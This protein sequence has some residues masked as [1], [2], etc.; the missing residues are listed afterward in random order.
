MVVICTLSPHLSFNCTFKTS[1]ALQRTSK[2][3]SIPRLSQSNKLCQLK[4]PSVFIHNLLRLKSTETTEFKTSLFYQ[5]VLEN[6]ANLPS[7]TSFNVGGFFSF[8][9]RNVSFL[10]INKVGERGVFYPLPCFNYTIY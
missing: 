4:K 5:S 1:S 2:L 7:I 8:L 10:K 9:Q 3:P 6:N